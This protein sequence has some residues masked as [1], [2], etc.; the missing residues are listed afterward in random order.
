MTNLFIGLFVGLLFGGLI[1]CFG[2]AVIALK[3]EVHRLNKEKSE[4]IKNV[5]QGNF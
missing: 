4:L 5:R 3:Y 1:G 2:T